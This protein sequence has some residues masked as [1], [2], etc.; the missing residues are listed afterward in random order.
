MKKIYSIGLLALLAASCKPTIEPE[1]P[2]K[3]EGTDFTRYVAVGNSLTAGFADGALYRTGQMNSYP[4]MLASQFKMV[5]GGDFKQPLV[6]GEYGYPG[7]KFVLAIHKGLCDT[8]AS[9]GPV[10][11][12]G[13]LDTAGTSQNIYAVEGPFNNMGIPGI[14]AVDYLIPGYGMVNPLAKR[15]FVS[16]AGSRPLDEMLILNPTFFSLWIGSNDVMGYATAGGEGGA[17]PTDKISDVNLFNAAYDSVLTRLKSRGAQGVLLNIPDVTAIPF[18]TTIPANG[19][20]LDKNNANLLNN[21]YNSLTHIRFEVGNNY[22]VIQDATAPAG[23]RQIKQGEYILLSTPQDSLKCAGW[24]TRKPIPANYV[25]TADEVAK[26]KAA[27]TAFN[28]IIQ[29]MAKRENLPMVD[30]NSYLKTIQSGIMY[31]GV[32]Y[33]ATFVSGGAFSL[34]G[35]HL[36]PRGYALVANKIIEAINNHYGATIPKVDVNKYNGVLFP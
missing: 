8:A 22:F 16:P 9:L 31:G 17:L 18:F 1:K 30:I 36:T 13:A 32:G 28:S 26:I 33:N 3:G 20:V 4:S 2:Q 29:M 5:G 6:P 23:I 27:T 19:L 12:T 24:G 15:M 34:D 10:P 25:L 11:F 7:P 14:R 21:A 35:M